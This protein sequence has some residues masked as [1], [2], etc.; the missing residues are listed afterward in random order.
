MNAFLQLLIT[1]L[2]F[3]W[4]HGFIIAALVV[5]FVWALLLSL[6]PTELRSFWFGIVAGVDVTS[7]GLLFGFG[8]GVLDKNQKVVSAIRLTP[9]PSWML[10]LARVIALG[11]LTGVTLILLGF[12]ILPASDLL[13]MLPGILLC[14]LFF[15]GMGVAS[16]RRFSTVNSF[17]V[18][19]A[20]SGFIWAMP[21]L[22][23]SDV[24]ASRF[25]VFLPSGGSM[26]LI[27]QAVFESSTMT[28]GLSYF[29]QV[30]WIGLTLYF[31]E[32]WA[33]AS[34]EHRFGGH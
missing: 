26:A 9:I 31:A 28:S 13:K 20:L 18:F 6:L 23:Y 10:S 32:K 19:F 30:V 17:M 1:E 12:M 29:S 8:L 15:A 2:K 34:F 14:S 5:T 11:L 33:P 24:V 7:I 16:S 21:I 27:K 22:Y 3:Q 25:W 4:R